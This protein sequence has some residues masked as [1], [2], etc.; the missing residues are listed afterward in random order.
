M[1]TFLQSLQRKHTAEFSEITELA[2]NRSNSA[3]SDDNLLIRGLVV[4]SQGQFSD[5]HSVIL[6]RTQTC[7]TPGKRTGRF[8]YLAS[9]RFI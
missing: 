7:K 8:V 6:L 3:G 2:P 4:F 1:C 5:K 9:I